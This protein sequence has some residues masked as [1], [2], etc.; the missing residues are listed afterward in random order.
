MQHKQIPELP[1]LLESHI[2]QSIHL[3]EEILIRIMIELPLSALPSIFLLNHH[4]YQFSNMDIIWENFYETY[5]PE[6]YPIARLNKLASQKNDADAKSAQAMNLLPISSLNWAQKFKNQWMESKIQTKR[7]R[8]ALSAN[9][10]ELIPNL[11]REIKADKSITNASESEQLKYLNV[12]SNVLETWDTENK[13]KLLAIALLVRHGA[14]I[15][16]LFEK[17]IA[18]QLTA[19]IQCLLLNFMGIK[20]SGLEL[21]E[22]VIRQWQ[23]NPHQLQEFKKQDNEFWKE[24]I[25]THLCR[26][27]KTSLFQLAIHFP[28]QS[29]FDFLLSFPPMNALDDAHAVI[30]KAEYYKVLMLEAIYN[31]KT[32]FINKLSKHLEE[33][34]VTNNQ[35]DLPFIYSV[36]S[37]LSCRPK[38]NT[39]LYN[40]ILPLIPLEKST[41]TFQEMNQIKRFMIDMPDSRLANTELASEGNLLHFA[42]E[43]ELYSF[44]LYLLENGQYPLLEKNLTKEN[45]LDI[46]L[47]QEVMAGF[48]LS[49]LAFAD[50]NKIELG[51]YRELLKQGVINAEDGDDLDFYDFDLSELNFTGLNVS[52]FNFYDDK[53]PSGFNFT[54]AILEDADF[55]KIQLPNANFSNAKLANSEFTKAK[56]ANANFTKAELAN[57]NF[58]NAELIQSNFS[59]ADLRGADFRDAN[60]KGVCFENANLSGA[61][62]RDAKLKGTNFKGVDLSKVLLE[63][64][65]REALMKAQALLEASSVSQVN[66]NSQLGLF[67]ASSASSSASSQATHDLQQNQTSSQSQPKKM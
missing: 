13:T 26:Q 56:L 22:Y 59:G 12:H 46:Y 34:K 7:D 43:L 2:F 63:K 64:S 41:Y 27:N 35:S 51:E 10:N 4:F 3:P 53:I 8:E 24:L 17:N 57:S 23:F 16:F 11:L 6:I 49:L 42:M 48:S 60:L 67:G 58:R 54:L 25:N 9:R 15:Q 28:Q 47:T 30:G 5:F 37:T 40:A 52:M 61:D 33:V 21:F 38:K 66:S 44:A 65:E 19:S 55:R 31:S 18:S 39:K 50:R 45:I 1:I 36:F 32:D 14:M 20:G 62:L 29:V